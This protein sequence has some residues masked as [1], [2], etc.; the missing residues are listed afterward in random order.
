MA[1]RRMLPVVSRSSL[2]VRLPVWCALVASLAVLCIPHP[3]GA[4]VGRS[5]NG[6][7]VIDPGDGF[8]VPNEPD[9]PLKRGMMVTFGL[10]PMTGPAGLWLATRH[11]AH[12]QFIRTI[13]ETRRPRR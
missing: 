8:G 6:L 7:P 9:A 11:A 4:S 13:K 2:A 12:L 10:H 1:P 3:G 5:R